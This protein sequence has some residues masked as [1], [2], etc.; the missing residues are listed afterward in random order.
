MCK[1]G[2]YWRSLHPFVVPP[3][4]CIFLVDIYAWSQVITTTF[5]WQMR[6]LHSL[7]LALASWPLE[8]QKNLI[9]PTRK[10]AVFARDW[11]RY[12]CDLDRQLLGDWGRK[13]SARPLGNIWR[14]END[15]L[16]VACTISGSQR[17]IAK[18]NQYPRCFSLKR[19]PHSACSQGRKRE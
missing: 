19:H 14:R 17:E 11:L 2:T 12:T 7:E 6:W 3:I 4:A 8:D 5:T 16:L 9:L 15:V 18:N 1:H 10:K 13:G